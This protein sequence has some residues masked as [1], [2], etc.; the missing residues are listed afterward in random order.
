MRMEPAELLHKFK[1]YCNWLAM[2]CGNDLGFFAPPTWLSIVNF[3]IVPFVCVYSGIGTSFAYQ[4]ELTAQS[5]VTS[6]AGVS[7]T[8]GRLSRK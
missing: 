5:P 4:C 3:C 2:F 6:K 1:L 7:D 8:C